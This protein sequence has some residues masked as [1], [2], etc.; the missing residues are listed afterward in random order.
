MDINTDP[1]GAG[2]MDPDIVP[3]SSLGQDVTMAL[4]GSAG[5]SD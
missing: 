1:S 5:L 2:T 3:G 4:D